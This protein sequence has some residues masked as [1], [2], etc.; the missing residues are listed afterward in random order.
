MLHQIVVVARFFRDFQ[1]F[2]KSW[3]GYISINLER[4]F[5]I[6]ENIKGK[7]AEGLY[8]QRG[9]LARPFVHSGM[10]TIAAIG[11]MLVPIISEELPGR[12]NP[13]QAPSPSS[14]LAAATE[15]PATST[16]VSDK[17]R[18]RIIE[19]E[20]Q[21]GDTISS[22]ADKFGI[23]QDT[24]IWENNLS[25]KT[26]LKP[27]QTLRILPVTGISHKVQ[28][29]ET[30]YSIA[31][32]LSAEPQAI[33]DFPF[34]TFV[35]D[36]TFALAVGQLLI[37]PDGT[38]AQEAPAPSSLARRTPDAGTV[39]ASGDFVWP[40]SGRISQGFVWYHRGVDIA[41]KDAPDILAADSGEVI[42]AGWPDNGGYGNR[43]I[44]DHGNG[45]TTLYAHLSQ[46]YVTAG[47][48]VRRGSP[49]GRMG[50]TGRSTGTHLHIEI[51][52]DGVAINP[53]ELLR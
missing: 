32:K 37:I 38:P 33:V 9:R 35:N 19:Y 4:W 51:K 7:I 41:N 17:V 11:I 16:L 8:R 34:N 46:I 1:E 44:I 48:T 6:F 52:R 27:G 42:L 3:W 50:S 53:L 29:G 47:Q 18:D 31:K 10:G 39:T 12:S 45:Y 36:E 30:I 49:I 24:I 20:I 21:P 26:V 25:K 43:V 23:S 40:A 2:A 22:I 13:W 15:N 5:F 14:V 28:K